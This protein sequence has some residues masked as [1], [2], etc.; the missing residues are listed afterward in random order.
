M[1]YRQISLESHEKCDFPQKSD[2]KPLLPNLQIKM[3]Q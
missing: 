3:L 2:T 1:K